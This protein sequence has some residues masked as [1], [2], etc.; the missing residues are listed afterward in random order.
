MSL[1]SMPCW[2]D[3]DVIQYEIDVV[4]EGHDALLVVTSRHDQPV[5][6]NTM[7]IGMFS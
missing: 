4:V 2:G 5:S 1:Q 6:V 7:K 3:A